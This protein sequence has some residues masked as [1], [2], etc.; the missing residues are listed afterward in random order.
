M[1]PIGLTLNK[2]L[3]CPMTS[4]NRYDSASGVLSSAF[5]YDEADEQE[6]RHFLKYEA[7]GEYID[8][9]D[10]QLSIKEILQKLNL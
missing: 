8:L 9:V 6:I 10:T 5:I 4:G 7:A 1:P 3:S 2:V